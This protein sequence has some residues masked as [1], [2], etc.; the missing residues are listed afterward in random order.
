[1]LLDFYITDEYIKRVLK[2]IDSIKQEGYY[3]KM[4]IAWALSVAY[5]KYPEI[6]M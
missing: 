6:T 2:L 4:A 1:M 3:V 5:V